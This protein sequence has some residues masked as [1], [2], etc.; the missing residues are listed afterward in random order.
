MASENVRRMIVGGLVAGGLVLG[1][2]AGC[3]EHQDDKKK[4]PVK[5]V[6]VTPAPKEKPADVKPGDVKPGE[7]KP[8]ETKPGETKPTETKPVAPAM[9]TQEVTIGKKQFALEVA[10]NGTTRFHGLSDR[11]EIKADGGMLFVFPDYQVAVHD[12]VMRDCPVPIDIIYLNKSGRI[13]A[14]YNMAAEPSRTEDEKTVTGPGGTNGK[15]ESR[16]KKYSSKFPSQFVIELRGGTLNIN[17]S[18]PGGIELKVN[19]RIELPYEELKKKAQ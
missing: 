8:G 13:T 19:D 4:E 9:R 15:Y 11:T 3:E 17:G 10:D 12:F 18:N 6:P 2:V 1:G 14:M 5:P 16:L 7:V